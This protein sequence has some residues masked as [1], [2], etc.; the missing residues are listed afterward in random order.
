VSY[1]LNVNT[2]MPLPPWMVF[3]YYFL[4]RYHASITPAP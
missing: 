4:S 3:T 1:A 2:H